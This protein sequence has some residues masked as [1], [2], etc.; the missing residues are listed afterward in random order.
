MKAP[1]WWANVGH[2]DFP[3]SSYKVDKA[4]LIALYLYNLVP[5]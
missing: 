5:K 1:E 3:F 4:E 2:L